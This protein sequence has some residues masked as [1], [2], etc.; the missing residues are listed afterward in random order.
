M[1]VFMRIIK[2][3]L[4][5]MAL[6]AAAHASTADTHVIFRMQPAVVVEAPEPKLSFTSK[7]DQ[8]LGGTVLSAPALYSGP[9][10][11]MMLSASGGTI[12][13][14]SEAACA[15]P[16]TSWSATAPAKGGQYVQAKVQGPPTPDASSTMTVSVGTAQASFVAASNSTPAS[17]G[18]F[19]ARSDATVGTRYQ[20][21]LATFLGFAEAPVS[22]S[23]GEYQICPVAGSCGAW[24]TSPGIIR[25]GDMVRLAGVSSSAYDTQVLVSLVA[26]T[27]TH[28]VSKS[29][30]LRTGMAP[31]QA[32]GSSGSY[33]VANG[34]TW[35]QSVT[36]SGGTGPYTFTRTAGSLPSGVSESSTSAGG[37]KLAGSTTAVGTYSYTIAIEDALKN[38]TT[39]TFSVV[40]ADPPPAYKVTP[41]Y[42]AFGPRGS[43]VTVSVTGPSNCQLGA[44]GATAAINSAV[45]LNSFGS[46]TVSG[47][48]RTYGAIVLQRIGNTPFYG[49][50]RF[51]WCTGPFQ[52]VDLVVQGS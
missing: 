6:L 38:K 20:S 9:A 34:A 7:A 28:S 32:A 12:R 39:R 10:Y 11:D 42:V 1:G 2:P 24:T 47:T 40:V 17:L 37:Y 8:L 33:A 18:S 29:W 26:G 27:T 5:S 45:T 14:C 36:A 43:T 41:S 13:T 30:S 35:N 51:Q 44:G 52:D 16:L 22:V 31:L 49:T 15:S 4:A 23:G 25:D 48:T 21:D 19:A 3:V 46:S 50:Y